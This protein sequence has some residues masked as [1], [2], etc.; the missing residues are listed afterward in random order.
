[1]ESILPLPV[2]SPRPVVPARASRGCSCPVLDQQG[3]CEELLVE[4]EQG[5]EAM[6]RDEIARRGKRLHGLSGRQREELE[7]FTRQ[8]LEHAVLARLRQVVG[9]RTAAA[10]EVRSMFPARG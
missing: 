10:R 5:L 8:L 2:L 7:R 9:S 1:M 6:R 4:V 3:S